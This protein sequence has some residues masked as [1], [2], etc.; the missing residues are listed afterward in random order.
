[1]TKTRAS[2]GT[3]TTP[4]R[5]TKKIRTNVDGQP[6]TPKTREKRKRKTAR[7]KANAAAKRAKPF[8]PVLNT[9]PKPVDEVAKAAAPT[10]Q[11]VGGKNKNK[12]KQTTPVRARLVTLGS[13]EHTNKNSDD[14]D[15]VIS[16]EDGDGD[17]DSKAPEEEEAVHDDSSD[18]DNS[19]DSVMDRFHRDA[20]RRRLQA[21]AQ[22]KIFEGEM[23]KA[24]VRRA[25][26]ERRGALL[27]DAE[28]PPND[29]TLTA[30]TSHARPDARMAVPR[31]GLLNEESIVP[32]E[33]SHV[34]KRIVLFVKTD[35]FR[36][37]KFV[38][39]ASMFQ[40]AFRKVIEFEK[41]RPQMHYQFQMTYEKTFNLALNQKR[42]SCEQSGLK[43]TRKT[44]TD[45]KK[46]GEDFFTME[47]LCKLRRATT[48]RERKAF[49]WFY[50]SFLECVC[51]AGS[52]R[53]GKKTSL[54]SEAR[55]GD[56]SKI[57]SI[58]DEAFGL[59]LIDN[60]LDKWKIKAANVTAGNESVDSTEPVNDNNTTEA[61]ADGGQ[62]KKKISR[63]PGKFT[64]KQSG[65]CKYSG[66][67]HEGMKRFN[68]LHQM[69]KEDR[70]C[71]QSEGME[72][73]LLA[74]CRTQA[75]MKNAGD[76]QQDGTGGGAGNNS[77]PTAEA[78]MPVEAA[79]DSDD[80]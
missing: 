4:P 10:K 72:R 3:R 16:E 67:S 24:E 37:I 59:L 68:E 11:V 53:T 29:A 23:E 20:A 17:G 41:V 55:D 19:T 48:D 39:S 40:R 49:F 36:K 50:D 63:L 15:F 21:A 65:K 8:A 13:G 77:L 76:E 43:I 58:S 64:E 42:S 71:P 26:F 28:A 80:D 33:E 5:K 52:W 69:V 75:G 7:A 60:Y 79:W 78:M 30:S 25:E 22:L 62:K 34:R 38:N 44:I 56:N 51:G 31:A 57:V 73:E 27:T 18:D 45:F 35:L 74:F 46:S 12:R 14:S 2:A 61:E 1:M 70:A 6:E 54:V 47:E 66:W 9:E 32:R